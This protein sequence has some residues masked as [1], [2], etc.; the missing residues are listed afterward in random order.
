M[1]SCIFCKIANHEI[2]GKIIYED[3]IC[4]A[5]LSKPNN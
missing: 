2:P 4:M 1:D 5:F 3:D